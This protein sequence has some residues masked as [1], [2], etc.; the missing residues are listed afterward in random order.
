MPVTAQQWAANWA[1]KYSQAGQRMT[2]GANALQTAPGYTAIQNGGMQ[3]W[4]A[5]CTAAQTKWETHTGQVTIQQWR[6]AY[7]K[8]GIPNAQNAIAT[9]KPNVMNFA[10]SAIPII[11]ALQTQVRAMPKVTLQD[12]LQRVSAWMTGMQQASAGG[13]FQTKHGAS[14]G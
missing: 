10:Q 7:I 13:Q 6:D 9:A 5:K 1:T 3:K 14:G 4:I 12:S 11:T 2:D 8:K